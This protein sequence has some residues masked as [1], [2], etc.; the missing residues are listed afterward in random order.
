METVPCVFLE[1]GTVPCVFLEM[2]T[3]VY[4]LVICVE[5]VICVVQEMVTALV[6]ALETHDDRGMV[7][8]VAQKG[9]ISSEYEI[10]DEVM[11]ISVLK[12]IS[13]NTVTSA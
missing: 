7:I 11:G 12:V 10:S 1:M 3:S 5:Q 13:W 4:Q 9:E 6:H 2:G 8:D